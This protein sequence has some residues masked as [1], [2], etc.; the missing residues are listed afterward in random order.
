MKS[1]DRVNLIDH[2]L[3]TTICNDIINGTLLTQ[4]P[5]LQVIVRRLPIKEETLANG[6]MTQGM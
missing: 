3:L 5:P 1:T 4:E 6:L 2:M